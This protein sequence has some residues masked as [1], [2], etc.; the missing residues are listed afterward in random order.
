MGVNRSVRPSSG[1]D[2]RPT[3]SGARLRIRVESCSATAAP[4]TTTATLTR[5]DLV[6]SREQEPPLKSRQDTDTGVNSRRLL[7]VACVRRNGGGD[8]SGENK[9]AEREQTA[10][11]RGWGE[12]RQRMTTVCDLPAHPKPVGEQ[13]RRW[14]GS[15][16]MMLGFWGSAAKVIHQRL[17]ACRRLSEVIVRR[18]PDFCEWVMAG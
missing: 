10:D 11:K 9:M 17:W 1:V 7:R 8:L 5:S 2:L 13:D 4:E 15:E 18:Y 16:V 3:S 12:D 14:V 6:Q